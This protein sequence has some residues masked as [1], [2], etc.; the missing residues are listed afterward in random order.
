MNAFNFRIGPRSYDTYLD[1]H[2]LKSIRDLHRDL[3]D[4]SRMLK[5][6]DARSAIVG[7]KEHPALLSYMTIVCS[8]KDG[9]LVRLW[10]DWSATTA[11]HV[12]TFCKEYNIPAPNKAEWLA[13][14]IGE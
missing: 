1:K 4:K 10:D 11:K 9:R 7:T 6:I 2:D 13:M 3:K 12:R 14:P 5:R 8:L